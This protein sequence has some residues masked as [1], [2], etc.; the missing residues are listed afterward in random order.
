MR[1][2]QAQLPAT[3]HY[4]AVSS[5]DMGMSQGHQNEEG[6]EGDSSW[7]STTVVSYR[8]SPTTAVAKV[9]DAAVTSGLLE[10]GTVAE[11]RDIGRRRLDSGD[12]ER[13]HWG[14]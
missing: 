1:Y 8:G 7:W 13:W 10:L 14:R 9:D 3:V 6:K 11:T 4:R 5:S 12:R 2:D